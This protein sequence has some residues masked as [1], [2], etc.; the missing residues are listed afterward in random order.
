MLSEGSPVS[1]VRLVGFHQPAEI[2]LTYPPSVLKRKKKKTHQV[3]ILGRSQ[4][5]MSV[6]G[7]FTKVQKNN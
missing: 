3:N 7:I 2:A 1:P 4:R 5:A 6:P